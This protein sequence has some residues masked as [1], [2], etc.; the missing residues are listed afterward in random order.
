M[1]I[2]YSQKK[3]VFSGTD[4]DIGSIN[5]KRKEINTIY[6]RIINADLTIKINNRWLKRSLK[7][8]S[9]FKGDMLGVRAKSATSS[10]YISRQFPQH[11]L[12]S[13]PVYWYIRK[14]FFPSFCRYYHL[15]LIVSYGINLRSIVSQRD[16]EA[17]PPAAAL[18]PT[19]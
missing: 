15:A 2:G 17:S 6:E 11:W 16:M 4:I 18:L 5:Y 10:F 3:V 13:A 9:S 8:F 7:K 19:T 12:I 1:C 14:S